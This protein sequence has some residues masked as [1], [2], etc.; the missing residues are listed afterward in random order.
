MSQNDL[1]AFACRSCNVTA[2]VS[3]ALVCLSAVAAGAV[4]EPRPASPPG[5]II[6]PPRPPQDD[7][8]ETPPAPDSRAPSG[9]GCPANNR[10][11]ELIV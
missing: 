3:A 4:D 7:Q 5:V 2:R 6:E 11:L 1:R 8:N 10:K 9:P